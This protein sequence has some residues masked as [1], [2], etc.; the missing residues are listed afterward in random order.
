MEVE[1][2]FTQATLRTPMKFGAGLIEAITLFR[3]RMRVETAAG[4]GADG[5]GAMLLSDLWAYPTP[6]DID[7]S[8]D[9]KD[10][11]LRQITLAA[12]DVYRSATEFAHPLRTSLALKREVESL[13]QRVETEHN[14]PAPVPVL[15]ALMCASPLDCALHDAFGKANGICTYDGYGPE[16]MSDDL[17]TWLGND[18]KGSYPSDFIKKTYDPTVSIWHLVGGVDKLSAAEKEHT[19]PDDGLPVSLDEWI[20]RDG[21]YCFKIKLRGVDFRQGAQAL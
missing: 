5:Y 4:Q 10:A 19:D 7:L 12:C 11:A 9:T 2:Q 8:H 14:L 6:E 17:S 16:F 3:V 18:F 21:V 1:P 15:A 20:R 13:A